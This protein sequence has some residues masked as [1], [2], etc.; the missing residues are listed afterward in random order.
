[1]KHF[2]LKTFLFVT[3][4]AI[5]LTACGQNNAKVKTI[6]IVNGDTTISEK[7]IGDKE[8]AEIEKQIT[9][10]VT[11]DSTNGKKMV[12]KIVINGDDKNSASLAYS[13]SNDENAEM[14]INADEKGNKTKIVITTDEKDDNGKKIIKKSTSKSSTK[15]ENELVDLNINVKN[16]VLKVDFT[17][18]SKE[19]INVSIMDENAKQVFY[20][21][22]KSGNKFSKEIKLDKKGIY[23]LNIVQN[24][25]ITT[26]KIIVE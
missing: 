21:T 25:K 6:T 5:V 10:I 19:P 2:Y 1:M 7:I 15:D 8:I 11:S 12:K 14:E 24:K 16:N 22:Q 13:F 17:S 3:A 18:A 23:F 9:M 26:E 4:I 20:E